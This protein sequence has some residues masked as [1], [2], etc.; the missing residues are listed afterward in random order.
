[1]LV[2]IK[3]NYRNRLRLYYFGRFPIK[4]RPRSV[5]AAV[6]TA[7]R[8]TNLLRSEPSLA[9]SSLAVPSPLAVPS[10]FARRSLTSAF[11]PTPTSRTASNHI[12]YSH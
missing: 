5:P 4:K 7:K 6:L 1:M 2:I 10:Q 8:P 12:L 3:L 9:R 11:R